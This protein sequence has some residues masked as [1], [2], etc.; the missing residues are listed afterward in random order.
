M[1]RIGNSDMVPGIFE[2]KRLRWF[3]AK[4]RA[5]G[6]LCYAFTMGHQA[7]EWRFGRYDK[8]AISPLQTAVVTW[9]DGTL[10]TVSVDRQKHGKK[11]GV[12]QYWIDL[13]KVKERCANSPYPK[14]RTNCDCVAH[15]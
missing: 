10:D 5:A 15:H 9:D 6:F 7:W 1:K 13:C 14:L 8:R 2:F 4:E 3:H 12:Y 11:H